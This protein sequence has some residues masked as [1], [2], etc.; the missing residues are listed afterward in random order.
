MRSMGRATST[1]RW[2]YELM[3]GKAQQ[4]QPKHRINNSLGDLGSGGEAEADGRMGTLC[5]GGLLVNLRR[6]TMP[7]WGYSHKTASGGLCSLLRTTH[8]SP[9]VHCLQDGC[10][11]TTTIQITAAT[12]PGS[13]P[14]DPASLLSCPA[15][16]GAQDF[17]CTSYSTYGV[18]RIGTRRTE[19]GT[20]RMGQ[21]SRQSHPC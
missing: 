19:R 16:Q 21:G 15:G 1:G 13:N 4:Q 9:A 10:K 18:C 2:V 3:L 7:G 12:I 14:T 8:A 6:A 5:L 17:S 11:G 20:P